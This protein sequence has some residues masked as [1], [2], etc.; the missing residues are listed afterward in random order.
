MLIATSWTQNIFSVYN[1]TTKNV[2]TLVHVWGK[3]PGGGERD[4][5]N[6]VA[7]SFLNVAM[8]LKYKKY[9]FVLIVID[10]SCNCTLPPLRRFCLFFFRHF[11]FLLMLAI[12]CCF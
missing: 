2:Y 7:Q 9:N 10:T 4:K 11:C 8:M 1:Y 5:K 3:L 12:F 6:N